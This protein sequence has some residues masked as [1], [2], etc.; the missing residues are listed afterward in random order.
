[1]EY[2]LNS[3]LP[4]SSRL[5]CEI[6]EKLIRDTSKT[7]GEYRRSQ[8]WIDGTNPAN[9]SFVPPPHNEI[10]GLMSNL[11]KFINDETMSS[12]IK[13]ALSHIQFETIH[14][15]LDGNGRSGVF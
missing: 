13:A 14:P 4:I 15:F 10:D 5:L 8:N 9:A 2:G 7:P 6:H 1:M 12:L 11:E 3:D